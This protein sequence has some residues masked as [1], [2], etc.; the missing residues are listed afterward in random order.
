MD[1]FRQAIDQLL[2][3][4][5]YLNLYF[6]G[7]PFLS[8]DLVAMIRYARERK[9]YTATSTN[10]HFLDETMAGETVRS[11]LS[12]LII[13]LDGTDQEAYGKYRVGGNFG[14]VMEG[15]RI[16]LAARKADRSSTPYIVLQFLVL[17]TNEHQIPGIRRLARELGVDRLEIKTAQL[18]GYEDGH[19]LMPQ[20]LSWSR[21]RQGPDGRFFPGKRI[22]NGCFRMWRGCV[23]TW[24]GMVVPCCFDKDAGHR[25]GDLKNKTFREI[26]KGEE[27]RVFRKRLLTARREVG[28]CGN[29][30]E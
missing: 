30:T 20:N 22:K 19:P 13:S 28:I 24:D 14:K 7:E 10:G 21:Y 6:Q 4:L 26:W 15:I 1:L 11:G 29:C 18:H 9:I 3:D 17:S 25:L 16:L 2:P 12:R 27:Y 5:S 23:I 8:K